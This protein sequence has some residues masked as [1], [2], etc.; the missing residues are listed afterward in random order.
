MIMFKQ[1]YLDEPVIVATI[2]KKY[3]YLE[4]AFTTRNWLIF[5]EKEMKRSTMEVVSCTSGTGGSWSSQ[6]FGTTSMYSGV[7][8]YR[9]VRSDLC[10]AFLDKLQFSMSMCKSFSLN[11]S[12]D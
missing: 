5:P 12:I 2:E 3:F 7:V 1:L 9:K 11:I 4:Y 6:K 8:S 10:V